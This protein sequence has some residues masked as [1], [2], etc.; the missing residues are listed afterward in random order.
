[1]AMAHQQSWDQAQAYD[2]S[3]LW[4]PPSDPRRGEVIGS[5]YVWNGYDQQ[6]DGRPPATPGRHSRRTVGNQPQRPRPDHARPERV[7]PTERAV[8]GNQLREPAVWCELSPC[9]S[10]YAESE[11]LGQSD[12]VARA[13][14]AGWC[15]DVFGRLICVA[16]QQRFPVWS[17]APLV[18]RVRGLFR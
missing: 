5:P 3:R 17:A 6:A 7:R 8:I 15:M 12:V 2:R 11:A 16:C 9:I 13:I 18:P 14:A 1:M 4:L 10:R